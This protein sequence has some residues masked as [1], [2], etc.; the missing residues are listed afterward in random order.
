[1]CGRFRQTRSQKLLEDR[2][3]AESEDEIEVI[4]RYNIAPHAA[5]GDRET[6]AGQIFTPPVQHALGT[7]SLLGEGHERERPGHQRP[8]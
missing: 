7:D 1:M 3:Q 4:P 6:G 5:G 8:L 2:F